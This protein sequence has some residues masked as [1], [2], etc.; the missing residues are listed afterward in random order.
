MQ[1]AGGLFCGTGARPTEQPI[2]GP[3]GGALLGGLLDRMA[4][5]RG[6][7]LPPNTPRRGSHGNPTTSTEGA[8]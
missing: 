8:A 5:L 7:P 6:N 2:T 4:R 1:A 3:I